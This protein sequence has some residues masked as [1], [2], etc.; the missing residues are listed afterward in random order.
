MNKKRYTHVVE[1]KC[2]EHAYG[3][4]GAMTLHSSITSFNNS[5]NFLVLR[6]YAFVHGHSR[7]QLSQLDYIY[8]FRHQDSVI[9]VQVLIYKLDGSSKAVQIYTTRLSLPEDLYILP[10]KLW[11]YVSQSSE[12]SGEARVHMRWAVI[13]LSGFLLQVTEAKP[14]YVPNI[15]LGQPPWKAVS[16]HRSH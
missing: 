16:S 4:L 12:L 7:A 10:V 6:T 9:C 11:H 2:P 15:T 1:Y 14:L 5:H 13:L 8:Y 3:W